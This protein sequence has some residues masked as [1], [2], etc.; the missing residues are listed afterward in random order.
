MSKSESCLHEGYTA[1][2]LKIPFGTRM[3]SV[4]GVR[5]DLVVTAEAS[6]VVKALRRAHVLT[7]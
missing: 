1:H 5:G 3:K 4:Y 7:E 6:P 2:G